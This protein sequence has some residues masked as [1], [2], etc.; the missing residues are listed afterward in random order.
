MCQNAAAENELAK[1]LD[2]LKEKLAI[3][4][5]LELVWLPSVRGPLSGEIKDKR[6][7]IYEAEEAKAIQTLVHELVDYLVTTRVV[8]PLVKLINL[9]V[10]STEADVY[11]AKEEVI[12]KLVGLY[13]GGA[14]G[15]HRSRAELKDSKVKGR[16][17]GA[18]AV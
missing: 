18:G 6:I 14:A 11:Q 5:E 4:E 8:R 9:L 15:I 2:E 12:E 1:A 13:G 16:R 7:Y 10:K 3:E 17:K